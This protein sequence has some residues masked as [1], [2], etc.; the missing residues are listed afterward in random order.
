MQGKGA[1]RRR[2]LPDTAL[3]RLGDGERWVCMEA[4][5][6]RRSLLGPLNESFSPSKLYMFFLSMFG[7]VF[8]EKGDLKVG[9]F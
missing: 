6:Q 9:I 3:R 8:D 7:G 4:R 2:K 5:H 1:V